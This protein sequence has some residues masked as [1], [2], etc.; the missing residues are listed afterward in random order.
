[1][2]AT[3]KLYRSEKYRVRSYEDMAK[4]FKTDGNGTIE[5]PAYFTTE[6]SVYCGTT[7]TIASESPIFKGCYKICEDNSRWLW[8]PCMLEPITLRIA[9]FL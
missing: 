5:T 9:D 2:K 3:R 1:M 6:M 7:V 8:D 4:E